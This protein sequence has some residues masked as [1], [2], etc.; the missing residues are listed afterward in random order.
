MFRQLY[1]L[2]QPFRA[3]YGRY[4]LGVTIRQALLVAGGYLLVGALRFA[5]SHTG[6][7]EWL[8]FLGFVVFD[9]GML[10]LD[11][12]LN[13]LFV[14][15]LGYPLFAHLRSSALAKV[16]EMPLEW[17]YRQDAGQLAGKVNNGVGKVVQT[18]ESIGRELAPAIIRTGL[19]LVPLCLLSPW[20]AVPIGIALVC[21]LWLT[22]AENR[23]R[24]PLRKNRFENYSRDFGLFAESIQYVKPVIQFGQ[25]RRVLDRYQQVQDSIRNDGVKETR[26]GNV[27]SWRRNMMLSVTKRLCQCVWIWQYRQGALDAA[28]VLYLNMVTEELLNSFWTY[29]ALIDRVQ[30]GM[31]PA[32]I[33]VKLLHEEPA[34]AT[35]TSEALPLPP[36]AAVAIDLVN[37]Q[38]SY[39]RG[40][41]VMRDLSLRVR[42][43]SI[44]GVVGP[45]GSGKTTIPNL[46]SRMFDVQGGEILVSGRDIRKWPLEQLR[47][48]FSYV[49]S[50]DGVFLSDTTL[51]D[52]IRFA[53]PEA[54]Q[55]EVTQAARIACIHED[56]ERMPDGYSTIVGQRGLTLSKG[57]QQRIALAQALLA[58]DDSR[59]VL[60]LDEFTSALDSGTERRILTNL[61]PLLRNR[62]V[63]IIAHRLS[64]IQD[65]ADEIVVM[66]NG[67]IVE[68]GT[69]EQLVERGGW[70]ARMARLQAIA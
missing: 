46:L 22:F 66:D 54:S 45:S 5:L 9:A 42:A 64:T 13:T 17:H 32:R 10:R 47:G 48:L 56:I 57:Q 41:K 59:R 7:P 2:L 61:L 35:T 24:Q 6:A 26:L 21:F 68:R 23:A 67:T 11:L 44:L 25:T 20:T 1:N 38:F 60:V 50:S 31:E 14:S 18:A 51:L 52:T 15:R 53:R 29:A 30:E 69:H 39:L 33:L 8:F 12:T 3:D 43:G 4:L 65:I 27:Y 34:I 19:S 55:A 28:T 63:I 37:I 49:S 70:Y 58:L 62:T 36:A 16:L 40:E